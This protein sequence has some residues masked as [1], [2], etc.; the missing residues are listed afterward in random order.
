M[1]QPDIREISLPELTAF[2]TTWGQPSFRA[3]QIYGWLW[4]HNAQSFEEMTN[5]PVLLREKL[6]EY[7]IF[8][9]I[10]LDKQQ[11]SEDGTIKARFRLHDGFNI[12][13]VLIPVIEE[14]RLTACVSIKYK[15]YIISKKDQFKNE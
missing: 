10:T 15:A 3:K 12:E 8:Q 2:L 1:K 7:Y 4:Q 5:L 11:I 9:N 14:N 6:N 13:S